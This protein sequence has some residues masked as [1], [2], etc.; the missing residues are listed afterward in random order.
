MRKYFSPKT[1]KLIHYFKENG[2]VARFS[3]IKKAGFHHDFLHHLEKEKK[4]EKLGHG[5]YR[6]TDVSPFSNPDLVITSLQVPKGVICLISAL[7]FHEATLEIPKHIDIAIPVGSR[8]NKVKYPPVRFYKFSSATWKAGI[9]DY[10]IDGHIVRVY[11][12][13]KTVAD[14]FKFRNKIGQDVALEAL[15]IAVSEKNINPNE[16]MGYAKICRV[17]KIIKP[18]LE[19]II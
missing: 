13:A 14:C 3:A 5:L 7:S 10:P 15:K 11:N 4:V 1:E 12:L 6:L 18:M 19:A 8:P 9:E 2:G 17:H 16:I